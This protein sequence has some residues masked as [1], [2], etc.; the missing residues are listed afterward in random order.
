MED[1][2]IIEL[3]SNLG[4]SRFLADS[5]MFKA[6][7]PQEK[8]GAYTTIINLQDENLLHSVTT[9]MFND[10]IPNAYPVPCQE[11][12]QAEATDNY[13]EFNLPTFTMSASKGNTSTIDFKGN[14]ITL[15]VVQSNKGVI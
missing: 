12:T 15:R 11:P 2:K 6:R 1:L 8:I 10:D 5:H 7:S 14:S 3:F 13:Q 4:M 9:D